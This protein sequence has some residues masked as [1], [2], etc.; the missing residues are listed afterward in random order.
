MREVIFVV[1]LVIICLI[2]MAFI[3]T[4]IEPV[5]ESKMIYNAAFKLEGIYVK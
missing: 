1:A 2:L 3:A 5:S 4:H